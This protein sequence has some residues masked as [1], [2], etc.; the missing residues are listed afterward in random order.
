MKKS[1]MVTDWG[2]DGEHSQGCGEKQE[3]KSR[4]SRNEGS[5]V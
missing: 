4:Q 1:S 5:G 3:K 2:N